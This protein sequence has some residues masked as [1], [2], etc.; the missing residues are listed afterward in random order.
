MPPRPRQKVVPWL[1]LGLIWCSTFYHVLPGASSNTSRTKHTLQSSTLGPWRK[2]DQQPLQPLSSLGR[3]ES[4]PP[5]CRQNLVLEK[6]ATA[7]EECGRMDTHAFTGRMGRNNMCLAAGSTG[8]LVQG[9]AGTY[10]GS[11]SSA[12]LRATAHS[13]EFAPP[14]QGVGRSSATSSAAG[15]LP[16]AQP[17]PSWAGLASAQRCP[18]SRAMFAPLLLLVATTSPP[19]HPSGSGL[20]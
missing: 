13:L 5:T 12:G 8:R 3:V 4:F 11:H 15:P 2:H 16:R 18:R 7:P 1:Y 17:Q 9:H 6:R 20:A 10:D 14:L 19:K